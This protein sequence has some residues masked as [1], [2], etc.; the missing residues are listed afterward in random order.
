MHSVINTPFELV[1]INV[2]QYR[3]VGTTLGVWRRVGGGG[4]TD[5]PLTLVAYFFL[6][7]GGGGGEAKK[8]YMDYTRLYQCLRLTFFFSCHPGKW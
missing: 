1:R 4:G 5:G 6:T 3:H 8:H 7:M 2:L